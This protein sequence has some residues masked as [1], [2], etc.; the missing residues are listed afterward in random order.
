MKI[1]NGIYF[2]NRDGAVVFCTMKKI[3]VKE[4]CE[5]K[6]LG[7]FKSVHTK[8]INYGYNFEFGLGD[9]KLIS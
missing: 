7:R 6:K 4:F 8:C 9:L 3:K 2:S 1:S 5:K